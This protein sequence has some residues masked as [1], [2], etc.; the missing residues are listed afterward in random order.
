[1]VPSSAP[2]DIDADVDRG[3]RR[4]PGRR[5]AGGG[6]VTRYEPISILTATPAGSAWRRQ[7]RKFWIAAQPRWVAEQVAR[8]QSLPVTLKR[9]DFIHTAA[10]WRV[11]RFPELPGVDREDDAFR[12]VLFTSNFNGGW[13]PYLDSFLDSFGRGIRGLWGRTRGFPAFPGPGTRYDLQRWVKTRLVCSELHYSAYPGATTHDVRAA[14]RVTREVRGF[15]GELDAAATASVARG[16]ALAGLARRLQ[17]CLGETA[18]VAHRWPASGPETANGSIGVLSLAPI[19]PGAEALIEEELQRL[20]RLPR[21]PFAGVPGTHFA[22]FGIIDRTRA[23]LHVGEQVVL[24]NSWLLF[25]ADFDGRIDG[26]SGRAR[27]PPMTEWRRFVSAIVEQGQIAALWD[28]CEGRGEARTLEEYLSRTL[29]DRFVGFR[30]YPFSTLRDVLI[31]L[32]VQDAFRRQVLDGAVTTDA[33]V[34]RLA[35]SVRAALAGDP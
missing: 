14:L 31:A 32:E 28:H 26:G 35:G 10:W 34:A 7:R 16:A 19:R 6:V 33:D 21:S 27:R 23:G 15:L 5:E 2:W 30:D 24:R 20:G 4:G 13:E 29:V 1:V 11:D 9:L 3:D 18:P 17:G 12:W 22:R 25:A 8:R